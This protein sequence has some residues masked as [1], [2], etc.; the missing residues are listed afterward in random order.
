MMLNLLDTVIVSSPS[1]DWMRNMSV[2]NP[3]AKNPSTSRRVNL[4]F[5]SLKP[6]ELAEQLTY[7]EYKAFRRIRV[8]LGPLLFSHSQGVCMT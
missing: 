2:R 5:N 8:S 1:Y 7:M 6:D 3:S 4:V